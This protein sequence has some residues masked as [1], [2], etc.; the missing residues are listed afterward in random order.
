MGVNGHLALLFI[1]ILFA[2]PCHGPMSHTVGIESAGSKYPEPPTTLL[3]SE[4]QQ[5]CVRTGCDHNSAFTKDLQLCSFIKSVEGIWTS[6]R[7]KLH[8][9]HLQHVK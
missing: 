6:H 3:S 9:S 2:I 4:I 5:R 8:L 7:E 1:S